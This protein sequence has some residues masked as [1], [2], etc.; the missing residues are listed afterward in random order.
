MEILKALGVDWTLFVHI[1]FFG[2][3]YLVFS[4]LILKPYMKAMHER[5]KRTIGNEANAIRLIEE[6]DKLHEQ[7]EI[8]AKAINS[9]IKGLYDQS[10]TEAM[11]AYDEMVKN[12]RGEAGIVTRRAQAEIEQQIQVARKTLSAEIPAIGA[13]IASKLAGKEISL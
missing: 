4:N 7:Y 9:E 8:K 12:A 6:A 2:I 11:A 13:T 3:S 5:E 1:I 10:R